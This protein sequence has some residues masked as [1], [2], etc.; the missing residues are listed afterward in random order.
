MIKHKNAFAAFSLGSE[1]CIGKNRTSAHHH[2][3]TL[4]LKGLHV[5]RVKYEA[6]DFPAVAMTEMRTLTALLLLNY[7]VAFA[8]GEDGT[9][10]L[11]NTIDHFTLGVGKLE[12]VFTPVSS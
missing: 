3:S 11:T 9:R 1:N 6:D 2:Q 10:L 4:R 5:C 8:D 7:D 12:L